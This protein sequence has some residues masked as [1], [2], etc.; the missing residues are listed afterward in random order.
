MHG[1]FIHSS[2]QVDPFFFSVRKTASIHRG[3]N[4]GIRGVIPFLCITELLQESISRHPDVFRSFWCTI[5]VAVSMEAMSPGPPLENLH[6]IPASHRSQSCYRE[7]ETRGSI[8]PPTDHQSWKS[9]RDKSIRHDCVSVQSL[10]PPLFGRARMLRLTKLFGWFWVVRV[11]YIYMARYWTALELFQTKT[12]GVLLFSPF[13][14]VGPCRCTLHACSSNLHHPF[15]P[16]ILAGRAAVATY[17]GRLTLF[18]LP[19]SS[20]VTIYELDGMEITSIS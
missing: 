6:G 19:W 14:I 8:L 7:M 11:A 15:Q 1:W 20:H 9:C 4:A 17:S 3:R 18:L 16:P 10:I 12:M 13:Q 2:I 5:I